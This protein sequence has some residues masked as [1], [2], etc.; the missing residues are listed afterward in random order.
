[1]KNY[2][3]GAV[4]E[5]PEGGNIMKKVFVFVILCSF[6]FSLS[7][8]GI[9]TSAATTAASA[10]LGG[11]QAWVF[12]PDVGA[13]SATNHKAPAGY[14]PLAGARL[15]VVGQNKYAITDSNGYAAIGGLADGTYTV[16]VGKDGYETFTYNN[17]NVSTGITIDVGGSS[18]VKTQ[19]STAPGIL[20]LNTLTG[21]AG[22]SVTITGVNFGS[23]QD[24]STVKFNGTPATATSWSTTQIVCSVPDG[25][26]SGNVVITVGSESSSGIYFTV[27]PPGS[28][29][30]LEVTPA[31]GLV[32]ASV[33]IT[34]RNFGSTKG[35]STVKFN[36][37]MAVIASSSNWSSTTIITTV[38]TGATTGN[39]VVRVGGVDS[40]S[41][42]FTVQNPAPQILGLDPTEGAVG[43]PV[44]I[45]G[46][47]FGDEQG[48]S[49]VTFGGVE[50]TIADPSDWS[51]TEIITTVPDGLE[52]G[53]KEVI[54]RV[55][56]VDSNV[57]EFT[58]TV[59]ISY[60]IAL[61][62]E[63][64][65]PTGKEKVYKINSQTHEITLLG[66]LTDLQWWNSQTLT[67]S[68]SGMVYTL[69][70]NGD[71]VSK[72]YLYNIN[73]SASSD[74]LIFDDFGQIAGLD[75]SGNLIVK[76]WI[77]ST[78]KVYSINTETG[79]ETLLGTIENYD[80]STDYETRINAA[81]DK[82]YS[83]ACDLEGTYKLFSFDLNA[84][85]S[86][87]ILIEQKTNPC[88]AGMDN[89]GK[90]IMLCWNDGTEQERV[91][92][93][94]PADGSLTLLG[95]IDDL[96]FW[97][98]LAKIDSINRKTYAIGSGEGVEFK[99]YSYDI[100]T[101]DSDYFIEEP[102]NFSLSGF[103]CP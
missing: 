49:T 88:L 3:Y 71:D 6:L 78:E 9:V 36:G 60:L 96:E 61:N 37:T 87:S 68:A 19:V 59:S 28:P 45:T 41:M 51:D 95:V 42:P 70:S 47:N 75:N 101:G 74:V 66:E 64:E 99:I 56:S 57:S 5:P 46:V 86:S 39:V 31:S 98:G 85:T 1:M 43:A 48:T 17:I 102:Y 89:D 82:I 52:A 12:V 100:A 8:C 24:S 94:D 62:Y 76:Y 67:D 35:Q 15:S 29:Q 33:T 90:L 50:A 80:G 58:V 63:G 4:H 20:D 11:M 25:A 27:T 83:I 84:K 44:T 26:T 91:Y 13:K 54:V 2:N 14:V 30:I 7:G 77:D 53:L 92:K 21:V 10:S 97:D 18:G 34:G 69:G 103:I 32:G 55:N 40:N 93:M 73:T 22:T 72:L 38:P 23:T 65:F 16:T 79:A 81:K